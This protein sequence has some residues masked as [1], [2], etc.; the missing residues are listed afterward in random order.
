[1]L[2]D[3]DPRVWDITKMPI[4]FYSTETQTIKAEGQA[5]RSIIIFKREKLYGYQ[6]KSNNLELSFHY[7]NM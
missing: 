5:F 3:C 6:A 1:M 2:L 7:V 4:F